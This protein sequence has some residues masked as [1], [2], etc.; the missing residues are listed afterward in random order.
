VAVLGTDAVIH[1]GARMAYD[2]TTG[3]RVSF[4]GEVNTTAG[5]V[6]FDNT[7]ECY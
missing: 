3:T 1:P 5:A 7:V 4:G 2:A 6:R